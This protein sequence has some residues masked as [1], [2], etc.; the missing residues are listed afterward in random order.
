MANQ[1][2]QYEV[3]AEVVEL[4]GKC[5]LFK[6]GDKFHFHRN[7]VHLEDFAGGKMCYHA[8][9]GMY[10]SVM[11]VRGGITESVFVQCLDPGPPY[12]PDGGTIIFKLTRGK[13]IVY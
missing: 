12:A 4:R 2:E 11:Q 9:C 8:L 13:R 10:G 7:A 6:V 3:V 1:G 5:P